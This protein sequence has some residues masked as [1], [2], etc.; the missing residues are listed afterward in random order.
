MSSGQ[1]ERERGVV[2]LPSRVVFSTGIFFF[3]LISWGDNG[4]LG[5]LKFSC[6]F[7]LCPSLKELPHIQARQDF[8]GRIGTVVALKP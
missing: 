4:P 5:E 2:L 3:F 1:R 6:P 7:W 8:S